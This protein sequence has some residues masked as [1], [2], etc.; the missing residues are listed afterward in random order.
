[1]CQPGKAHFE[2]NIQGNSLCSIKCYENCV[3][4][5]VTA[6]LAVIHISVFYFQCKNRPSFHSL[7][8]IMTSYLIDFDVLEDDR[9]DTTERK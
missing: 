4:S 9:P 6:S 1:M 7:P 8:S 3:Q 2:I 5:C